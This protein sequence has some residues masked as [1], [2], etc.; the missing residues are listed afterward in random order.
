MPLITAMKIP[1]ITITERSQL[2]AASPLMSFVS[3]LGFVYERLI[4]FYVIFR[5][6]SPLRFTYFLLT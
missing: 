1:I 3:L 2:S 4:D 5:S 6:L